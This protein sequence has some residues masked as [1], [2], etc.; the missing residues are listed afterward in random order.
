MVHLWS[1][2]EGD[3]HNVHQ[4][5]LS[6]LVNL[7]TL[8]HL[9]L[10]LISILFLTFTANPALS[11]S[12]Q[13]FEDA[14]GQYSV[15]DIVNNPSW[16][17]EDLD[18]S[19]GITNST[20]WIKVEFSN[21][22]PASTVQI[23]RFKSLGLPTVEEYSLVDQDTE[24][25]KHGYSVPLDARASN[26]RYPSFS[27]W[28]QEGDRSIRYYKLQSDY[29]IDLDFEILN[30]TE[31][32]ETE[33]KALSWHVALFAS[34]CLILLINVINLV[35]FRAREY[36]WYSLFLLSSTVYL[37]LFVRLYEYI[38][39][40][41]NPFMWDVYSGIVIYVSA[42]LFYYEL[43]QKNLSKF[44][45]KV[46]LAGI[47]FTTS[48]SFIPTAWALVVFCFVSGPV[49]FSSLTFIIIQAYHRSAH[50]AKFAIISW[51]PYLIFSSLYVLNYIGF[52]GYDYEY[53]IIYGNLI[54]AVS[55]SFVL[56]SR[57]DTL[58]SKELLLD[59]ISQ[60]NRSLQ[61]QASILEN[62][63][64]ELA[65][66]NE[67][68]RHKNDLVEQQ[69]HALEIQAKTDPLT[70]LWNRLGLNDQLEIMEGAER[71]QDLAV[72][73]LDVDF[74]KSVNDTYSHRVGD[75]LLIAIGKTLRD[76]SQE[77]ALVARL[78]G[79]EFLVATPWI[80]VETAKDFGGTLRRAVGET[81]IQSE[82]NTVSST[83]SVGIAKLSR[84]DSLDK[85]LSLAD[86]ALSEAKARGRNRDILAD[87]AFHTEMGA[88]GAFITEAEI[89]A[90]LLAHE[91]KY[92]VQPIY[93]TEHKEV[94]GFETLIR[95][96][97]PDGSVVPPDM[98]LGQF[99]K[100]FFKPELQEVRTKMRYD[101]LDN[102]RCYPD[103]YVSWNYEL[104]Q[105]LSDD[106]TERFITQA[107]EAVEKY[108]TQLVVEIS[109]RAINA[110]IDMADIE[111]NLQRIRD[112]GFL[113]ALDDFGTEQSNINR[114]MR[115]PIDI[116]K[117][118]KSLIEACDTDNRAASTIRALS[119]LSDTLNIKVIGEG[120]ETKRQASVLHF[121]RVN[122]QQGY[123]HARPMDPEILATQDVEIGQEVTRASTPVMTLEEYLG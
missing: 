118:D 22:H 69:K 70:G 110:R 52:V 89:E 62:Q 39:V 23:L 18:P 88:R 56:F 100:V 85:A 54:H 109:E 66:S 93:N 19:K 81:Q 87:E 14:S 97:K 95:W 113:I 20:F 43:F 35:F 115:L 37:V 74:F 58:H 103:A 121:A 82:G 11:T 46:V 91:F 117:F 120:V 79:E 1:A 78:G 112:A 41:T 6:K 7:V 31:L 123:F 67:E 102:L 86:L 45:R 60:Q 107:R 9:F 61:D 63:T 3:Q 65:V 57:L 29:K 25:R 24:I 122:R 55:L 104:D 94:E 40:V 98:F 12:M 15:S 49:I 92:Y 8:Q 33:R 64:E 77:N 116:L 99:N 47:L 84:T 4:T 27:V 50:E 44:A 96:I 30:E 10:V 111:R 32:L 101:V 16:F 13:V 48:H 105:F 90:G 80:D 59:K 75:D 2:V 28:L 26:S 51:I 21:P 68:L 108:G 5:T 83:T 38:G 17:A 71:D 119:I 106:I 42:Y 114:L 53:S 34:M 73:L 72:Y 36:A 76:V